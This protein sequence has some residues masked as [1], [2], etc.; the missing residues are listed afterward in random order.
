MHLE[1]LQACGDLELRDG[2]Y[3]AAAEHFQTLM[4][5]KPE[6]ARALASLIVALSHTDLAQAEEVSAF[7]A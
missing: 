6:D 2:S 1:L 4:A 5:N 7:N 3:E